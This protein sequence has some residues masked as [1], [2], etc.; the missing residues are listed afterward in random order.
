MSDIWYELERKALPA[1]HDVTDAVARMTSRILLSF[2]DQGDGIDGIE[3]GSLTS[4][5]HG[6][7]NRLRVT[8]SVA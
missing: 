1:G 3:H 8:G 7:S 6:S 4:R 2:R 5:P